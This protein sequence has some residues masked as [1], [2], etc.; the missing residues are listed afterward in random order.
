MSSEKLG[1]R[2][3]IRQSRFQN[4]EN[5]IYLAVAQNYEKTRLCFFRQV[6]PSVRSAGRPSRTAPRP[7]VPRPAQEDEIVRLGPQRLEVLEAQKSKSTTKDFVANSGTSQK[8]AKK[9]LKVIDFKSE[10]IDHTISNIRASRRSR[11]PA[12]ANRL[13]DEREQ[14]QKERALERGQIIP[15]I[16]D[17][18]QMEKDDL[19]IDESLMYLAV[20]LKS[21]TPKNKKNLSKGKRRFEN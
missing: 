10:F 1:I 3:S 18:S 20:A 16:R 8:G 21:P 15:K 2:D 7:E 5:L 12:D 14:S 4:I 17:I 19:K 11:V 9:P 13:C 6:D